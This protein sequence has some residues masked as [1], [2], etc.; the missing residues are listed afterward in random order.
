M[1]YATKLSMI[2][3]IDAMILQL[4]T[5]KLILSQQKE[6]VK[7]NPASPIE[8]EVEFSKEEDS[9]LEKYINE[10]FASVKAQFNG[11]V[12]DELEEIN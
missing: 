2:A 12:I 11:E 10:G 4:N 3:T 9:L 5:M 7:P 8:K 1:K 6:R